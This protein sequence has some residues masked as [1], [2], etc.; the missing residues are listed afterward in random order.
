VTPSYRYLF[1]QAVREEAD[2]GE[3]VDWPDEEDVSDD[4]E[5]E[6]T[7]QQNASAETRVT[8]ALADLADRQ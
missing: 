4:E 2:E 5:Q 6:P 3:E 8:G 1:F 7:P